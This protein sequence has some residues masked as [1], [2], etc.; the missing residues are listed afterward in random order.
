MTWGTPR[1][2]PERAAR[3][4]RVLVVGIGGSALGPQ[5][6]ASALGTPADR[7]QIHFFDNTDPDGIDRTLDA[8]GDD[9]GATLAVIISKS[10]GT[11]ET[12]N[13]MLELE[14]AY[15]RHGL[16]LGADLY[17][18]YVKRLASFC[19]FALTATCLFGQACAPS[20]NNYDTFYVAASSPSLEVTVTGADAK[21]RYV[22]TGMAT[23]TS[24]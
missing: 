4:S 16:S 9:L 5:F 11:K 10:G 12:R 2:R 1:R 24:K 14:A 20:A 8:I 23:I 18:S 21:A 17:V 13:G 6:V 7:M 3:F 19:Y 15:R 22:D